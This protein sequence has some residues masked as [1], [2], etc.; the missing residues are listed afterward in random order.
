MVDPNTQPDTPVVYKTHLHTHTAWVSGSFQQFLIPGRTR[1]DD[2]VVITPSDQRALDAHHRRGAV[3]ARDV[4]AV[5]LSLHLGKLE[6]IA[7]LTAL[8]ENPAHPLRERHISQILDSL[9]SIAE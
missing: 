3:E 9:E 7:A 8:E 6:R 5:P 2:Y 1:L 4:Y